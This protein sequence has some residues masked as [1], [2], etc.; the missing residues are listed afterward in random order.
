RRSWY[1]PFMLCGWAYDDST[2]TKWYGIGFIWFLLRLVLAA[3][4]FIVDL[5][6]TIFFLIGQV[7]FML[8]GPS[9]WPGGLG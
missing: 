9:L 3:F 6:F 4:L 1:K 5:V 8:F 7:V 2:L